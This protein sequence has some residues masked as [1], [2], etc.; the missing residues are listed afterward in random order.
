MRKK[1]FTFIL[2]FTTYGGI[3]F[4]LYIENFIYFPVL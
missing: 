1:G 2:M 4:I 3:Y